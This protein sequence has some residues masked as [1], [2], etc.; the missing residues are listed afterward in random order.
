MK[1]KKSVKKTVVKFGGSSLADHEK[2]YASIRSSG[3]EM[4][5][6]GLPRI[7]KKPP[8]HISRLKEN[9]DQAVKRKDYSQARLL[10]TQYL[11]TN[12]FDLEQLFQYAKVCHSLGD[13]PT[14][15]D[16]LGKILLFKP[17]MSQAL[18]LKK[19]IEARLK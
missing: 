11:E 16:S 5:N 8:A 18:E 3:L 17:D 15:L 19:K 6:Q 10:L 1:N 13:I 9:I 12:P 4:L 2:F 7:S 14:A